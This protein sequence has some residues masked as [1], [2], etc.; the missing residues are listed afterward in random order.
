MRADV[1]FRLY[2]CDVCS[3][4]WVHVQDWRGGL[5]DPG[6]EEAGWRCDVCG[7]PVEEVGN[8]LLCDARDVKGKRGVFPM[9]RQ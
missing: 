2:R 7:G 4:D 6:H 9:P 1:L 5:R 3:Q 8:P